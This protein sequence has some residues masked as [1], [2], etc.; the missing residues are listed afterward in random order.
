MTVDEIIP[1]VERLRVAEAALALAKS[2]FDGAAREH[3]AAHDELAVA[4]DQLD[5]EPAP[6]EI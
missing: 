6:E 3:A 5:T 1:Y 4:L 2:A